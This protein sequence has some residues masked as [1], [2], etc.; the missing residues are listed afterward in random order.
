VSGVSIPVVEVSAVPENGYLLDVREEDEWRAG[1]A[2]NAVHIPLG[3]LAER[4]AEI[5]KDTRCMSCAGSVD[6]P[7]V[8]SRPSTRQGGGPRTS[9]GG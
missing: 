2:P 9:L 1:H 3:Q 5:P 4:A 7:H 6:A 8:P